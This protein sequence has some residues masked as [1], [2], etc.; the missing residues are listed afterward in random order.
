VNVDVYGLTIQS[1]YANVH[2]YQAGNRY[3]AGASAAAA[4]GLTRWRFRAMVD[5]MSESAERWGGVVNTTEGNIGRVD[6]MAGLEAAYTIN[7]DWRAAFGLKV[8]LYTHVVGGQ[9]DVPVYASLT[10]STHVQLW[11]PKHAHPPAINAAGADWSGLDE[12]ELSGDGRAP[13]LVPVAGKIT[14]FDF[15]ADWCRPCNQLDHALA[16]VA[17]RHPDDIAVRKVNVVDSDSPAWTAHLAPGSF[18]LPHVKLFGR[19][20]TLVWERSGSPAALAAAVEDAITG[21]HVE[22]ATIPSDAVRVDV[23]VTD[24]GY[25]PERIVVPRGRPAVLVFTR[26]SEKTC[27]VDVH[28]ALPD[29]TKIDRRLPL[30]Q[31]V[32]IPLRLDQPGE[33][34]Y[35]CGMDMLHGTIVVQ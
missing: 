4:F 6:I 35:A 12:R 29:G 22:A 23:T 18:D 26:T 11:T 19:D 31:P 30:G 16:E 17:R 32:A 28:F 34:T 25:T 2:G 1:L 7:D 24:D 9:V 5:R 33:I 13:A 27:A 3:A 15:W 20:G 10:V 14:V 21:T 8:P